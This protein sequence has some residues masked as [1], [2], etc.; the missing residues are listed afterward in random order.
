ML[1]RDIGSRPCT[2]VPALIETWRTISC[3]RKSIGYA[4]SAVELRLEVGTLKVYEHW[5][6]KKLMCV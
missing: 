6:R 4:K 3:D 5:G 2:Q 1:K